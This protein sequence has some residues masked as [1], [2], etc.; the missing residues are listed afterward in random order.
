[1]KSSSQGKRKK[2]ETSQ[3]HSRNPFNAVKKPAKLA[4]RRPQKVSAVH[5]E[6]KDTPGVSF[7]EKSS[8]NVTLAKS[9]KSEGPVLGQHTTQKSHSAKIKMLLFPL[10]ESMRLGLEEDGYNPFLELTLSPK[11]KISSVMKHLKTKWGR[12]RVAIGEIML[13]PFNTLPKNLP[14]SLRWTQNDINITAREVHVAAGSPPCFRLSYGWISAEQLNIS[15]VPHLSR[16]FEASVTPD[17]NREESSIYLEGKQD[18][19]DR[20]G[21]LQEELRKT[22]DVNKA[23]HPG[24]DDQFHP[25]VAFDNLG[26]GINIDDSPA[27]TLVLWDDLTNL[28]IG[29]LLSEVSMQAKIKHSNKDPE[30]KSRL[31]FEAISQCKNRNPI[32]FLEKDA[33][34]G[35][36]KSTQLMSAINVGGLVNKLPE[37][38]NMDKGALHSEFSW[39]DSITNLSIGGLLSE[40]SLHG[41][42][43]CSPTKLRDSKVCTQETVPFNSFNC[44]LPESSPQPSPLL[45]PE[46]HTSIFDA[47]ETCNAFAFKNFASSRNASTSGG[48][49][50]ASHSRKNFAFNFGSTR[51][52]STSG[53]VSSAGNSTDCFSTKP[54]RPLQTIDEKGKIMPAE[55]QHHKEVPLPLPQFL[56]DEES[57]LGLSGIKWNDTRGPFD[58]GLPTSR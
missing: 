10:T 51:N 46:S 37:K 27:K 35:G 3:Q 25:D 41:K 44:V 14:S 24:A 33:D 8:T 53:E 45:L 34:D 22:I 16:S 18:Q 58:L 28:S 2:A 13:F 52:V 43:S 48:V 29:G 50:C 31:Q 56:H 21:I 47:E 57:S 42:I 5:E 39:D 55:D 38:A 49:S 36:P 6:D 17:S 54:S 4:I 15:E 7:R 19:P 9:G 20:L 11:K 30:S 1:M 23:A 12:S 32:Q 40:V 26:N